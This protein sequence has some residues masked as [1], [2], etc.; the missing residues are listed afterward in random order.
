MLP[1][2]S[3]ALYAAT[4]RGYRANLQGGQFF[5]Y[6]ARNHFPTQLRSDPMHITVVGGKGDASALSLYQRALAHPKNYRRIEWW[7]RAEG[8]LPN[9]HVTYRKLTKSA[10]FICTDKICSS[11]VY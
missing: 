1:V 3:F 4:T 9:A 10:A 2:V 7:D 8:K 5:G 6:S 11:P